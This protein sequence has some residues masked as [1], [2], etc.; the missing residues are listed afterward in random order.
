MCGRT[1]AEGA[2]ANKR[3]RAPGGG[4]VLGQTKRSCRHPMPSARRSKRHADF[5]GDIPGHC[6]PDLK[7]P[8]KGPSNYKWRYPIEVG[9]NRKLR[10]M[11][12]YSAPEVAS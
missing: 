11:P 5:C 12:S 6:R 8:P 3:A 2:K 4:T 7:I 9:P 1:A 10:K